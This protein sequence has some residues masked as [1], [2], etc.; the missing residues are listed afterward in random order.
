MEDDIRLTMIDASICS[1]M[2][3]Q[4]VQEN[5]ATVVFGLT[6][7]ER[8]VF[9][10]G[11]LP[12]D[13]GPRVCVE[14][15]AEHTDKT[16]AARLDA[17]GAEVLVSAWRTPSLKAFVGADRCCS[18][19]YV[20][21]VTGSIRPVVPRELLL[22]GLTATNWGG[23]VAPMVAEHAVL[24]ALAALRNLPA[25]SD[26]MRSTDYRTAKENLHT[27]TL[28]NR[29]VGLHGFGQIAQALTNLLRPFGARVSAYSEGVPPELM[30]ELG[31]TPAESLDALFENSDVLIECEAL[32]PATV[33]LVSRQLL[34]RLPADAVFVNV[35]RGAIVDE[36]ALREMAAT[37]RIRVALDVLAREP[38][39]SDSP[40]WTTRGVLLSPH[41]GGPTQDSYA[42]CGAFA[43]AN[44]RRY[45]AGEPLEAVVTPELYDRST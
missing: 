7:T 33:G 10:P 6:R 28:R 15:P 14:D 37:K 17:L 24:L 23:S 26:C 43:V 21:H 36:A 5:A 2:C 32:T 9:F 3:G 40:W 34:S 38:L 11:G 16:W 13:L 19:K 35:G 44:L 45:L 8:E 42:A 27:R 18:V 41:I 31:V 12:A 20:C 1:G 4:R 22:R 29:R 39:P 25:W 30:T